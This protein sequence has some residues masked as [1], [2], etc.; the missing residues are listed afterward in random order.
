MSNEIARKK[1]KNKQK[2]SSKLTEDRRTTLGFTVSFKLK[3][4][5]NKKQT[6]EWKTMSEI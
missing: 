4:Q 6:R 5:N 1:N 2:I 3:S